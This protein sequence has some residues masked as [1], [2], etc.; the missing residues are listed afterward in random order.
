MSTRRNPGWLNTLV[1]LLALAAWAGPVAAA[2][3][4]V[5]TVPPLYSLVES[6]MD[7]V[8]KPELL[9]D[10]PEDLESNRLNATRTLELVTADMVIWVG[11]GLE[12]SLATALADLPHVRA[13]AVTVGRHLPLLHAVPGSRWMSVVD[14]TGT[15]HDPQFWLDPRLAVMAVRHITPQLV[16]MD[17]DN[18]DTYLDNE[19]RLVGQLRKLEQD[20][21]VR[22]VPLQGR[23]VALAPDAPR[24]LAWR[25]GLVDA[26]LDSTAANADVAVLELD[27]L[28]YGAVRD[29]GSYFTLMERNLN[30]LLATLEPEA[31]P[32]VR[33]ASRMRTA[34]AL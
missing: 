20:L 15:A 18:C 16:K 34:P 5:V 10:R 12:R 4:V 26:R 31:T 19:I 7:G 22:L 30:T 21:H 14:E 25:F 17:P 24:Y 9:Y 33:T 2:P 8:G 3:Q 1:I 27:A 6:L 28:G 11:P 13:N 32:L 29:G 23:A